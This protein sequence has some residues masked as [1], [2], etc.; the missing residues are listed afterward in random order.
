M[1]LKKKKK[2]QLKLVREK[3]NLR[4]REMIDYLKEF[5]LRYSERAATQEK[6][7]IIH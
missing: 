7:F 1:Q 5:E 4:G 2:N 3:K 6:D